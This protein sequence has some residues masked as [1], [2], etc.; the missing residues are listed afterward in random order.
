MRRRE[1]LSM[2]GS[3]AAWPLAARAQQAAMPVVGFLG[4]E[5]A[6]LWKSRLDEFRQ[7]LAQ[8]GQVEGRDTTIEPRWGEG[9]YAGM[10][11][12]AADLVRRQVAV[13]VA[14]D[15]AAALAARR[16]T[17]TIPIVFTTN[18]EPMSEGLVSGLNRP[19]GNLTCVGFFSGA[20]AARRLALL[21]DLVP[22]AQV[23]AFLMDP[24]TEVSTAA[25]GGMR[26]RRHA[27][28]A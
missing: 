16:A 4:S 1:F 18:G 6:E 28:P 20:V 24:K 7:G 23:V 27:R 13:I 25:N 12:L 22:T 11:A 8:T 14:S 17:T 9:Q 10:P 21:R 5:T 19:G 15:N 2:L 26:S 3:A